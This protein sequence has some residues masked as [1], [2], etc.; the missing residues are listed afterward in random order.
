MSY[1]RLPPEIK[2]LVTQHIHWSDAKY[3]ERQNTSSD[4]VP[5]VSTYEKPV[6]T[7]ALRGKGIANW[8]RVNKECRQLCSKILF[9]VSLP[10][11]KV[12]LCSELLGTH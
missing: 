5:R 9:E 12:L 4:D 2:Q 11:L 6:M 8:S 1:Q 10:F 3:K 7:M